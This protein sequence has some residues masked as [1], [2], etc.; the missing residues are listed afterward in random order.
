MPF[1]V[2]SLGRKAMLPA[3]I[4]IFSRAGCDQAAKHVAATCTEGRTQLLS[5]EESKVV[6][7]RISAFRE[8]HPDLPLDDERL[9]L[10]H[11]GVAS[12]HAGMLPIEKGLIESL[13]QDGLLKAIFATETLAAGINMPA[14]CTVITVISKRGD[15]GIAT[16][17]PSSFLQM[18]GR[19]GRR[20]KD[21]LGHV[22]VCRSLYEDAAAAPQ[23]LLQ[24]P[25]PIR[26][27][28]Y[29][30]YGSAL[31][32]LRTRKVEECRGLVERSFGSYLASATERSADEAKEAMA[33][34]L[35]RVNDLLAAHS[36]AE[37]AAYVKLAER[38]T[39]EQRT[40]TYLIEQEAATTT[41]TIE[42]LLPFVLSG[43]AARLT[44]GSAA[45]LLDDAPAEIAARMP[46]LFA[47]EAVLLLLAGPSLRICEPRHISVLDPD[48]ILED[49]SGPLDPEQRASVL[50]GLP[51][52]AAWTLT[53]DGALEATFDGA[54]YSASASEAEASEAPS[55][56]TNGEADD[57]AAIPASAPTAEARVHA[58]SAASSL[59]SRLVDLEDPGPSA[60]VLKQV[61][62]VGWVRDQLEALPLH[63]IPK[64]E[65]VLEAYRAKADLERKQSKRMRRGRAADDGGG[66]DGGGIAGGTWRQFEAVGEVLHQ[67]GALTDWSATEFGELVAELGGE[68]E[69][70]LAI[71]MLELADKSQL[72]PQEL[73][74]VL[75]ATLDERVRPNAYVGYFS[76]PAVLETLEQLDERAEDLADAQIERGLTFPCTVELSAVPLVEAWAAGEEWRQLLANT[77]LDGGDI[78]R[79]LRRTIELLRSVADVPYVSD[80]VKE[81]A[82]AA[83]R[84]M[85]RYPLA[86]N[87][88][89]GLETIQGEGAAAAEDEGEEAAE[90]AA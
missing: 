33:D 26:S 58:A 4:F 14:R 6:E 32:M 46:T 40:E 86:D 16:L 79:I 87:V 85:N 72:Q 68:N 10:L 70:W 36:E 77:S 52:P 44:D 59:A 21:E 20:G 62:R 47:A 90:V 7:D 19:A 64:R 53:I 55:V 66:G 81:R 28:F 15:K 56:D 43:T 25:E 61:A 24:P 63:D 8:R 42:S 82:S 30:T 76:S 35:S 67:F 51:P 3:I 23:L 38:L 29:V 84:A 22:V 88:L 34:E 2:R 89:M 75:A 31:Q 50:A 60:A 27:H 5:A 73:A 9:K 39:A 83:L 13:F 17:A 1:L 37:L 74:A 41:Q 69:L 18:A 71:V 80:A 57:E 45:M 49:G 11:K 54:D 65:A 48:A 78:F 12:H